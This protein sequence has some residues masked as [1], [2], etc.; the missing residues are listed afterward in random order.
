[1][2]DEEKIRGETGREGNN[3]HNERNER[4]GEGRERYIRLCRKA[5]AMGI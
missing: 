4:S 1:M 2:W 5:E 3:C